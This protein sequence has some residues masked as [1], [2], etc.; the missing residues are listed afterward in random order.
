MNTNHLHE[1]SNSTWFM[2]STLWPSPTHSLTSKQRVSW[3]YCCH[4][5]SL[6]AYTVNSQ[7]P[8]QKFLLSHQQDLGESNVAAPKQVHTHTHTCMGMGSWNSWGPCA[9]NHCGFPQGMRTSVSNQVHQEQHHQACSEGCHL[10][11]LPEFRRPTQLR[12][13][14]RLCARAGSALSSTQ[15][16]QQ[17]EHT[18]Q[19][20]NTALM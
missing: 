12:H 17:K 14:L 20:P 15:H 2:T 16:L 8:A 11:T 4:P 7:C 6:S 1:C 10:L 13:L 9:K 5:T 18:R 3:W 19:T